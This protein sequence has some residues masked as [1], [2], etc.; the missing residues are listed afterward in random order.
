MMKIF[1]VTIMVFLL[2]GCSSMNSDFTCP[3]KNGIRCQSLDEV[4]T[5]ID[6]GTFN[7]E[8]KAIEKQKITFKYKYRNNVNARPIRG[9]EQ[10]IKVWIAPYVD[11][12]GNYHQATEIYTVVGKPHWIIKGAYNA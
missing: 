8:K 6:T 12:K 4:N 11:K 1:P 2:C 10:V 9:S 3:M 5:A 7:L